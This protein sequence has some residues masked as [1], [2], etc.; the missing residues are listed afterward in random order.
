MLDGAGPR[1]PGHCD[2][3]DWGRMVRRE[4]PQEGLGQELMMWP[5]I[6]SR[7]PLRVK[8]AVDMSVTKGS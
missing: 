8:I 3:I 2:G 4:K 6:I 5:I 7:L 1:L